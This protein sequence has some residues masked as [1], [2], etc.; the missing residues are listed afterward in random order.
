MSDIIDRIR[1]HAITHYE[2]NGWDILVECW[3][4]ADILERI[5]G[6]NAEEA[7]VHLL[8]ILSV[9]DDYRTEIRLA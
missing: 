5:D 8:D 9:I 3:T 4:D 7:I 2:E 6:K 1:Q